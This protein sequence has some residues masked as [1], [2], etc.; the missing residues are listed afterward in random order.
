[1]TVPRMELIDPIQSRKEEI[2]TI[3]GRLI[4]NHGKILTLLNKDTIK[5]SKSFL[6]T[7]SKVIKLNLKNLK[8]RSIILSGSILFILI[9]KT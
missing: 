1:M 3:W 6:N 8:L 5:Q 2:I 7:W 9:L 4:V